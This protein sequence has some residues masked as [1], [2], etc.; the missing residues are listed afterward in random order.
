MPEPG[1]DMEAMGAEGAG[2]RPDQACFHALADAY[3]RAGAVEGDEG[4]GDEGGC[5]RGGALA[6]GRGCG[7]IG[8]PHAAGK[9]RHGSM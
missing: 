2:P 7:G 6:A 4:G 3:A 1:D 8:T 5:L 9:P